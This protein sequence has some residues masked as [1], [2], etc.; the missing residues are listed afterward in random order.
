[1]VC[2]LMHETCV[3]LYCCDVFF[4]SENASEI[5]CKTEPNVTV[6]LRRN[7][8]L[9]LK[10]STFADELLFRNTR[11]GVTLKSRESYFRCAQFCLSLI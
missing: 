1:V 10:V 5:L 6:D 9:P 2:V 7:I 8:Y 3:A 4:L 11:K